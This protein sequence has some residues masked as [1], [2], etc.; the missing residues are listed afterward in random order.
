MEYRHVK[1]HMW[2]SVEVN[3][4]R[5]RISSAYKWYYMRILWHYLLIGTYILGIVKA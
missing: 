3:R 2:H 4:E 1:R 5:K